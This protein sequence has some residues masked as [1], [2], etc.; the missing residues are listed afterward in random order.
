[1]TSQFENHLRAV[2]GM[3]LGSTRTPG[4]CAML[5]LIGSLPDQAAILKIDGA[6]LHIYGKEAR[7]GR[8]LGHVTLVERNHG[9]LNEKLELLKELIDK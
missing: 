8:K 9:P 5:N 6:H 4:S 1:V 2:A 7:P 3:P